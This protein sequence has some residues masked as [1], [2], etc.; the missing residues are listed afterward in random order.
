MKSLAPHKNSYS[1]PPK[2]HSLEILTAF[3]A[4]FS[5]MPSRNPYRPQARR[6][7]T[8]LSM[9]L[10]LAAVLLLVRINA[11]G[12]ENSSLRKILRESATQSARARAALRAL[13]VQHRE[14][15]AEVDLRQATHKHD[16]QIQK[17]V[18]ARPGST[19]LHRR[20][21]QHDARTRR[22]LNTQA[23]ERKGARVETKAGGAAATASGRV[24]AQAARGSAAKALSHL[25]QQSGSMRGTKCDRVAPDVLQAH[26]RA[27]ASQSDSMLLARRLAERCTGEAIAITVL[28]SVTQIC[29]LDNF[30]AYVDALPSAPPTVV[31]NLDQ[32]GFDGCAKLAARMDHHSVVCAKNFVRRGG[33]N[34]V[35]PKVSYGSRLWR[36]MVWKKPAMVLAALDAGLST[37][38]SD[39]DLV[40]LRD[41]ARGRG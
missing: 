24:E 25:V 36:K 4:C 10:A 2:L 1:P 20:G 7:L 33:A 26:Y 38:F 41:P 11:A 21:P 29:M 27:G 15:Q 12:N 16:A 23:H 28:S 8:P 22:A 32:G 39:I 6:I 31:S 9:T 5:S 37:Y 35:G 34:M 19:Q 17:H 18:L 13:E 3:G 30:L 40:L 14:A